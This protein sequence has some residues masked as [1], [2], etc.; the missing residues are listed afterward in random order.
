MLY[1]MQ[2]MNSNSVGV[3]DVKYVQNPV[4]TGSNLNPNVQMGIVNTGQ[5]MYN[6]VKNSSQN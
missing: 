3:G 1:Q 4:S 2:Q 6:N 5:M